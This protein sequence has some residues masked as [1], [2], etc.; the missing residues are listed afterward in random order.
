MN[1]LDYKDHKP[2][3]PTRGILPELLFEPLLVEPLA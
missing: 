2:K 3:E 1:E